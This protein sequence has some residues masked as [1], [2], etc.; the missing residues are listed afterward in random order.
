MIEGRSFRP[1]DIFCMKKEL[2]SKPVAVW[3]LAGLCCLL[4]GSAFPAIK[5]GYQLFQIDTK[6]TASVILFAGVRFWLAGVLTLIIFSLLE[7]KLLLPQ[8]GSIK[9]IGVLSVFQTVLQYVFFYLGLAYT[10]GERGSIINAS[11]VFFALLVSALLFRFEKLNG[12]KII[13]ML[14]GFIGVVL[15]SLDGSSKGNGTPR[16]DVFILISA[17]SY[18]FSSAFMKRYSKEDNPAMLSGWQFMLGGAVMTV[19]GL[20][21]GGRAGAMSFKALLLLLYLALL[22]AVAYSVWSILLKYNSVSSVAVC[23][24]MTPI[25]GYFLSAV[26]LDDGGSIGLLS[27]VALLLAVSG[28]IIVNWKRES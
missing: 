11:G 9:R 21:F 15:I 24:F 4:W 12:A 23:G 16:G 22:S 28:I 5:I 18:A 13:G 3:L 25:F 6:N 17:L 2:F 8:E 10:T 27:V 7:K 19:G 26:F 1:P 14:I 20:L